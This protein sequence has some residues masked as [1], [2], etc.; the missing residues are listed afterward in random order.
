MEAAMGFAYRLTIPRSHPLANIWV[1]TEYD[2]S[3]RSVS[4]RAEPQCAY[5]SA[6]AYFAR[7]LAN[8]MAESCVRA[9]TNSAP[10][11]RSLA[12]LKVG[13][14]ICRI[15]RFVKIPLTGFLLHETAGGGNNGVRR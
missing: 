10:G 8:S 5:A 3:D 7:V 11:Y 4:E 1:A 14:A 13:P 2:F 6:K 12:S 9:P 15:S